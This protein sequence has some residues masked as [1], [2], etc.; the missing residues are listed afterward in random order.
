MI[1]LTSERRLPN[2]EVLP[3]DPVFVEWFERVNSGARFHLN[4]ADELVGPDREPYLRLPLARDG[5]DGH[6]FRELALYLYSRNVGALLTQTDGNLEAGSDHLQV[7]YGD[8][9]DFL[10]TG[11]MQDRVPCTSPWGYPDNFQEDGIGE[12]QEPGLTLLPMGVRRY[13]SWLFDKIGATDHGVS[14][15]Q[16]SNGLKFLCFMFQGPDDLTEEQ[17]QNAARRLFFSLPRHYAV[18]VLETDNVQGH[19]LL[20]Q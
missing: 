1:F 7:S 20:P 17:Y 2:G 4:F 6:T 8:V 13:A 9:V 15:V 5:E 18:V 3:P 10:A 19:F 16:A 14:L 12:I 11:L